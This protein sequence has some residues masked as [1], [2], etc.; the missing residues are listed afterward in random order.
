VRGMVSRAA[1][2]A[3]AVKPNPGTARRL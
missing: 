3:T 1:R 2:P